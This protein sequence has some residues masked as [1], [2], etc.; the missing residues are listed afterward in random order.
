MN[1]IKA[2]KLTNVLGG[3]I[4]MDFIRKTVLPCTILFVFVIGISYFLKSYMVAE[5]LQAEQV[6]EN[7]YENINGFSLSSDDSA[8][9]KKLGAASVYGE[10]LYGSLEVLLDTLHINNN[11]VFYDFGS[12]VGKAAMQVALNTNAKKVVGLELSADR[13]NRAIRAKERLAELGYKNHADRLIFQE[14][15]FLEVPINDATIVYLC[16]TCFPD[17]MMEKIVNKIIDL[18]QPVKIISLRPIDNQVAQ[19]VNEYKLPMSWSEGLPVYIYQTIKEL[20]T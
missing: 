11:D 15:D 12:G 10:I 6:I 14:E 16:S 2:I 8:T 4:K 18:D 9:M 7:I 19:L 13:I 20:N 17:D 3:A 1:V 5:A